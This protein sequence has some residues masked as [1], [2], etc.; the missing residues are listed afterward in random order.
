[1][2]PAYVQRDS[3]CGD[4]PAGGRRDSI[5]LASPS[6]AGMMRSM[7]AV[8]SLSANSGS[9]TRCSRRSSTV[10]ATWSGE[11]CSR[12]VRMRWRSN[13]V[14]PVLLSP[15]TISSGLSAKLSTTGARSS[16]R[17]PITTCS[18]P[19]YSA[20]TAC[21]ARLVGSSRTGGAAMPG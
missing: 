16:S 8:Y 17:C 2:W 9:S 19:R 7:L 1:M 4:R 14:L 20:P 5:R 21:G 6:I 10:K 3:S 11:E 13:V 15:N 12:T 18:G